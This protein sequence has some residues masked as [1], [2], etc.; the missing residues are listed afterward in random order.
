LKRTA[1]IRVPLRVVVHNLAKFGALLCCEIFTVF[2]GLWLR[3]A[4]QHLVRN[5]T[6]FQPTSLQQRPRHLQKIDYQLQPKAIV[7]FLE[8]IGGVCAKAAA[9]GWSSSGV[10]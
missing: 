2:L 5:V 4:P 10:L 9:S 7:V 8:Y 6:Q 3:Q 1:L